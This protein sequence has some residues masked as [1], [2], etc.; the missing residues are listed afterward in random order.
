MKKIYFAAVAVG[1]TISLNAQTVYEQYLDGEI[2]FKLKNE[3]VDDTPYEKNGAVNLNEVAWLKDVLKDQ[4]IRSIRKPFWMTGDLK[5]ERTY[6]LEFTEIYK[7]DEIIRLIQ[8]DDRVEFA[9]KIAKREY[10]YTPND[11][12]VSDGN[13]QYLHHIN[14]LGAWDHS[15]GDNIVIAITDSGTDT[16]HPDLVDNLWVNTAEKNGI[17][18]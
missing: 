18:P 17:E 14:A 11:K 3:V 12:A 7:V 6:H 13:Q 15:K 16:G 5:L 2:Y 9:E 4:K 10:T 8:S 1:L